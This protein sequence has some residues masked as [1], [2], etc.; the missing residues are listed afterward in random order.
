MAAV[1]FTY[2][3][4]ISHLAFRTFIIE[5]LKTRLDGEGPLSVLNSMTLIFE[6]FL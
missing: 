6:H 2:N 5:I 1:Y 4:N 3:I